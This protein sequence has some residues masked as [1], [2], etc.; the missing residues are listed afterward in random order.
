MLTLNT[1]L[2]P[3]LSVSPLSRDSSSPALR[4][5]PPTRQGGHV[6]PTSSR[7]KELHA[8]PESLLRGGLVCDPTS[9]CP[10]SF[11]P[12]CAC[13][14]GFC[15]ASRVS[16]LLCWPV[17]RTAAALATRPSS[18]DTWLPLTAAHHCHGS[19]DFS[20]FQHWVLQA[21][22]APPAPEEPCPQG[23]LPPF[24]RAGLNEGAGCYPDQEVF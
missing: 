20:P 21:Q 12:E 13:R 10:R 17:P 2:R 7:V 1:W 14:R 23:A 15:T 5:A 6:R 18:V 22:A 4:S 11:V 16:L 19:E 3:C 8:G 24:R 9:S